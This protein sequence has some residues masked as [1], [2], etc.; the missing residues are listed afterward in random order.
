MITSQRETLGILGISNVMT[1]DPTLLRDDYLESTAT[2][3]AD[4]MEPR[5]RCSA[6]SVHFVSTFR[7][8]NLAIEHCPFGS[9]IFPQLETSVLAFGIFKCQP[10]LMTRGHFCVIF[11]Q[12]YFGN[13]YLKQQSAWLSR[14]I[15]WAQLYC[16]VCYN[17]G[18][19]KEIVSQSVLSLASNLATTRNPDFQQV[20][21][22]EDDLASHDIVHSKHDL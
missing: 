5:V 19:H 12:P 17:Y 16:A 22:S 20:E 11:N 21:Y 15:F 4:F 14:P 18:N 1:L 13:S 2:P 3:R 6:D 7:R 9:M 10:H 8:S